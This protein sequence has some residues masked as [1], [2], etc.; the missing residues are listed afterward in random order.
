MTTFPALAL[1]APAR[2]RHHWLPRV[3]LTVTSLGLVLAAVNA[4]RPMLGAVLTD[5]QLGVEPGFEGLAVNTAVVI[6]WT[7]LAVVVL[8]AH[9]LARFVDTRW[10]GAGDSL[11]RRPATVGVHVAVFALFGAALTTTEDAHPIA[12]ALPDPLL[13][14]A[15]AG[16]ACLGAWTRRDA[17]LSGRVQAALAAAGFA[18]LTTLGL[19][20]WF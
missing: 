14:V 9:G 20:R 5:R 2:S 1:P 18:L 12:A 11:L 17:P 13:L 8:L 19:G 15:V 6:L 3:T 7:S 16:A 4:R 10:A